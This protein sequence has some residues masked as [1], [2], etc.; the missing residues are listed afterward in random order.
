[1]TTDTVPSTPGRGRPPLCPPESAVR[2]IQLRLQGLSYQAISYVLNREGV[3]TPLVRAKWTK[4]HVSR[5]LFARRM[6]GKHGG[7]GCFQPA[8]S[9]PRWGASREPTVS[10]YRATRSILKR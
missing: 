2:I 8:I 6:R 4:S 5:L 3:P 7:V 1:M 10:R 9:Y